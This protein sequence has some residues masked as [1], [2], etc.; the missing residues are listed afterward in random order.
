M[1]KLEKYLR[2][3]YRIELV[4][5][6]EESGYIAYFPELRG[7]ISVGETPEEAIANAMDAK[8]EWLTAALEDGLSIPEPEAQED[9]SGQFKLRIPKALHRELAYRARQEGVSM[10]QYCLYLLSQNIGLRS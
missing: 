1:K 5:D 7:C 6:E 2:R 8:K 4:P 9:F 10:N 3:A